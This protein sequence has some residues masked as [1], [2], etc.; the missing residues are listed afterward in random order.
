MKGTKAAAGGALVTLLSVLP[1]VGFQAKAA[2]SVAP[3]AGT[4][5]TCSMTMT[6]V[7]FDGPATGGSFGANGTC[8]DLTTL[9]RFSGYLYDDGIPPPIGCPPPQAVFTLILPSVSSGYDMTWTEASGVAT[10]ALGGTIAPVL[11]VTHPDAIVGPLQAFPGGGTLGLAT[12]VA[13]ET[14]NVQPSGIGSIRSS[15]SGPMVLTFRAPAPH[16]A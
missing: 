9:A 1:A 10:N 7:T 14:C 13:V 4:P 3:Q 11:A 16:P 2:S 15:D 12:A 6:E 5:M 8:I